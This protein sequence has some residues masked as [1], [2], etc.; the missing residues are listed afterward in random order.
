MNLTHYHTL[1]LKNESSLRILSVLLLANLSKI[2]FLLNFDS[3]SQFK[4]YAV[5][6]K[7]KLSCI[8]FYV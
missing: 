7:C 5:A 4:C 1:P 3:K 6:L 8:V 2:T